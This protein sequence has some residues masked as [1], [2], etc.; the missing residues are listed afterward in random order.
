M[1][2]LGGWSSLGGII[3]FYS[4]IHIDRAQ[5]PAMFE[6]WR[7]ALQPDGWLLVSFHVG[8][9]DRRPEALWGVPI[10]IDF[11]FFTAEEIEAPTHRGGVHDRGA[12]RARPVCW[13]RG[14]HKALLSARQ[15]LALEQ[16]H[17]VVPSAQLGAH[18]ATPLPRRCR[19]P[20]LLL[21]PPSGS[22]AIRS[23][24]ALASCGPA[25]IGQV[26]GVVRRVLPA[27]SGIRAV[28]LMRCAMLNRR[29][30]QL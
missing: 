7:E 1:T 10:E 29:C 13:G 30:R 8:T 5:Q 9:E 12:A 17:E 25:R 6:R 19:P 3:A 2:S 18:P 21:P 26:H 11:L 14:G 24:I 15:T 28:A 27:A 20:C 16:L 23:A 22:Q 4:I